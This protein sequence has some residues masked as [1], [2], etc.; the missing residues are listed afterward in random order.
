MR[1]IDNDESKK[2]VAVEDF[3]AYYSTFFAD[4]F[5]FK[6]LEQRVENGGELHCAISKKIIACGLATPTGK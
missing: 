5:S 4:Y 2:A 1:N 3:L 6:R